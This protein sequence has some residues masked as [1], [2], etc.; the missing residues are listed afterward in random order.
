MIFWATAFEGIE[1][2]NITRTAI[3]RRVRRRRDFLNVKLSDQRPE[4]ANVRKI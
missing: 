2:Q 1:A 3:D 4:L